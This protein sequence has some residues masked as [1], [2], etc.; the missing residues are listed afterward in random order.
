MKVSKTRTGIAKKEP[1]VKPKIPVAEKP[2]TVKGNRK[3][4]V[5][6]TQIRDISMNM[7]EEISFAPTPY[8]KKLA[9]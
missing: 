1:K 5:A 8:H 7:G 3:K 9:V 4:P 6:D 2:V